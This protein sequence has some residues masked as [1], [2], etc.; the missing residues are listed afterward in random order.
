[1]VRLSRILAAV[2]LASSASPISAA[3]H[4]AKSKHFIIYADSSAAELKAYGE[5]LERFDQAVRKVRSMADP[6]LTDAQRPTIFALKDEDAVGKTVGNDS[7]LGLYVTSAAGSYAFVPRTAGYYAKRAELNP[8]TVFFHEYAH[9]LQLGTTTAALPAWMSEGFA[10]FFGTAEIMHNGSVRIGRP[11]Q[12]RQW[13]VQRYDGF[14]IV[15]MLAGS[16]RN[17]TSREISSLYGRGWLLTHMLTFSPARRGQLKRYVDALQ[18]GTQ[19]LKAAKDAFGDDLRSLD[20]DMDAYLRQSRFNTLVVEGGALAVGPIEVRPL[21]PGEAAVMATRMELRRGLDRKEAQRVVARARKIAELHASD[22]AVQVVLAEAELAAKSPAAAEAAARRAYALEPSGAAALAIGRAMVENGRKAPAG[23]DWKE[24]RSW[25][26]RANKADSENAEP[27]M[28]FYRT[29]LH[30]GA[31]PTSNAVEGLMYAVALAPRDEDLRI[32]AVRQLV[33]DNRLR[34]AQTL[35]APSAYYPHSGDVWR[36]R[37]ASIVE[38]L[39][40]SNRDAALALLD[41][42][43]SERRARAED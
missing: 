18:G 35:F 32:E 14:T 4:E 10:E 36:A 11:P 7:L 31:K 13:W 39:A 33:A 24:V 28:L 42:E 38:A 43:Q 29:F 37:K 40:R 23:T 12:D 41:A 22:P 6:S 34:E 3:W 16:L 25:I 2:A 5:R 9:H 26:A 8:E 30:A 20:R 19:P 1:M 15:E 21:R 17:A 27:L